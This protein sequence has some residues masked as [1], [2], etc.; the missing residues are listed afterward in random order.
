MV[1]TEKI[2]SLAYHGQHTQDVLV[3]AGSSVAVPFTLV[4]LEAGSLVLEVAVLDK[5]APAGDRVQKKLRVVVSG[6]GGG[7]WEHCYCEARVLGV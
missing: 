6:E 4:P 5:N 1:K 2:C 3:P 7:T